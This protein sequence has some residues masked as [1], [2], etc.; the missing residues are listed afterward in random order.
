MVINIRN[1]KEYFRF[2][3]VE[4]YFAHASDCNAVTS[5]TQCEWDAEGQTLTAHLETNCSDKQNCDLLIQIVTGSI[6]R[7][8][9][10]PGMREEDYSHYNTRTIVQDTFSDLLKVNATKEFSAAFNTESKPYAELRFHGS[11]EGHM[12]IIRVWYKPFRV[13]VLRQISG[14]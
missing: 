9:F 6:V 10:H 4:D 14:G 5:M 12:T 1:S 2:Q 11:Q 3:N 13:E 7:V 8:R